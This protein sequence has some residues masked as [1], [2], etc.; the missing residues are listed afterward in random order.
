MGVDSA[1]VLSLE[2]KVWDA[3]VRND[4]SALSELFS[5]D[6]FEI[7]FDGQRV[8]KA[9]V[10]SE[11]PK[12][13]QIDEYS[14]GSERV[15]AHGPDRAVLSYHLTLKGSCRGVEISPG[16]RWATSI[17]SR[18]GD[19]WKCSMFQQSPYKTAET[20]PAATAAA[21]EDCS[22]DF[23]PTKAELEFLDE[24]LDLFNAEQTGRDDFESVNLVKRAKDGAILAGLKGVTGW[25]WLYIQQLWVHEDQRRSGIGS[26]LMKAA[27]KIG[28]ERGCIGSCLTSYTFQAPEFYERHEYTTFGQ[29]A[30]YPMGQNMHF[31]SKLF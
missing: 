23:S 8:I 30:D 19:D 27:E 16:D 13:D 15:V 5:D 4:G 20:Q 17:W 12:V 31:M 29:I 6:Y 10:V 28:K 14:I 18:M 26:E 25:D 3:V 24:Q 22:I 11:S 1:F 7:T 21:R 2:H 9:E